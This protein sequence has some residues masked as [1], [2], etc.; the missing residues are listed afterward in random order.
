M[1]LVIV[2]GSLHSLQMQF[3]PHFHYNIASIFQKSSLLSQ[4]SILISADMENKDRSLDN[5]SFPVL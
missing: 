2:H 3:C 5:L 1:L 4:I